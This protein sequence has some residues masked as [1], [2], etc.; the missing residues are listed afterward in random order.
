[1]D[2]ATVIVSCLFSN[3]DV[4]LL[5]EIIVLL[6]IGIS[7][8]DLMLDGLLVSRALFSSLNNV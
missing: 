1:M 5:M 7:S 8:R 2:E 4:F 3:H 6:I